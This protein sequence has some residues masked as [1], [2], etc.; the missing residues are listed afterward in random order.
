MRTSLLLLLLQLPSS[1][2][3][4][5]RSTSLPTPAAASSPPYPFNN[6]SLPTAQRVA[7]LLSRMTLHEKVG[8]MF[9]DRDMAWGHDAPPKGDVDEASTA[10][11][12]LGVPEFIFMGQG[13]VYR[14]AS[15]GCIVN[16]CSCYDG[17]NMSNCCHDGAA[18]Q[19]PQGTGVAATW[20]MTLIHD[21]GRI[22]ADESR[23][24]MHFPG[25][26]KAADYRTGASSVIN[27]LRDGRWGR[28]PETYG[29]CPVL[30][31]DVAVRLPSVNVTLLR[32][33]SITEYTLLQYFYNM[34][35]SQNS[36]LSTHC[37]LLTPPPH[38]TPPSPPH[39]HTLN[40]RRSPSTKD[41]RGS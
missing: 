18:T 36:R 23:G 11:D 24:M 30:T 9:M 10:I 2:S 17:K 3:S 8:Q 20:N 32:P 7:D 40:F 27:I 16:C 13:N 6:A 12:R 5:S 38:P 4:S 34:P 25:K 29:E 21:M 31:G 39:A 14:G 22:A 15:N 28:A 35:P 26:R 33:D 37:L 19:F 41:C 1:S